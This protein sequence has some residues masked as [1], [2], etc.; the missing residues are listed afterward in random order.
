MLK[1][2]EIKQ[3]LKNQWVKEIIM[4]I[5]KCF[6]LNVYETTIY[7]VVSIANAVLR[8]QFIVLKCI[9]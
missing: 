4:E 2:F 9:H 7:Q 6:K 8:G 3:W 1:Y 5:K